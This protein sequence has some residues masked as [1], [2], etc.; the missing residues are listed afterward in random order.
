MLLKPVSFCSDPDDLQVGGIKEI[1]SKFLTFSVVKGQWQTVLASITGLCRST[2]NSLWLRLVK[3][4][5]LDVTHMWQVL[6]GVLPMYF[7]LQ[8]SHAV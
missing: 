7:S 5:I 8:I 6:E 4:I 2:C 1:D 3:L